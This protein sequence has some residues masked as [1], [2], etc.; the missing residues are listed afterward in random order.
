MRS[1]YKRVKKRG[2]KSRKGHKGG[3]FSQ[4]KRKTLSE[5]IEY[6][7]LQRDSQMRLYRTLPKRINM[8]K[9]EI[10]EIEQQLHRTYS[11]REP[12]DDDDYEYG[13][14]ISKINKKRE[15]LKNKKQE[16]KEQLRNAISAKQKLDK[17][18]IPHDE[19]IETLSRDTNSLFSRLPSEI[20]GS[21][22]D[23]GHLTEFLESRSNR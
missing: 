15:L 5:K 3:M 19:V 20:V 4:K 16:K 10:A 14:N 17:I 6:G 9:G 1:S 8:L 2:R 12:D 7:D 13:S 21:S 11:V 23:N 18:Y 22:R